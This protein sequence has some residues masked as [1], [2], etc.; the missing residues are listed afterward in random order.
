MLKSA[1]LG[2]A[3]YEPDEVSGYA[4]GIGL[5]RL[6]QVELGLRSLRELWRPPYLEF[7]Q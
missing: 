3:G 7:A 5:E 6:A 4:L 2:E 1:M